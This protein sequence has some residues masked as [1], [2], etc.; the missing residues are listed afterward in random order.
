MPGAQA[1]ANAGRRLVP[2]MGPPGSVSIQALGGAI[3]KQVGAAVKSAMGGNAQ[4]KAKSQARRRKNKLSEA[5][6]NS[7]LRSIPTQVLAKPERFARGAPTS[8]SFAPRGQGLYDAFV[9]VP[10]SMVLAS[11]VG[12]VTVVEGYAHSVI[13]GPTPVDGVFEQRSLPA[14]GGNSPSNPFGIYPTAAVKGNPVIIA[15]NPGSSTSHMATVYKLVTVESANGPLVNVECEE[16]HA[17][18]LAGIGG[19]ST[20]FANPYSGGGEA[21]P[22]YSEGSSLGPGK[23]LPYGTS[24]VTGAIESIPLRGSIKFRNITEHRNIGG[25]VRVM[26]YNGGLNLLGQT[27]SNWD[28]ANGGF[29]YFMSASGNF[30]TLAGEYTYDTSSQSYT[31]NTNIYPVRSIT[32]ET[33]LEIVDMM[34]DSARSLPLSGHDLVVAHQ[35]NTYPADFVRSHTFRWDDTFQE[36]VLNPKY[37]TTL[38]LIDDFSP[39]TG[40]GS[41]SAPNNTYSITCKVQRACR[42]KP[43]TQ[44]HNKAIT[45]PADSQRHSKAAAYESLTAFARPVMQR[46]KEEFEKVGAVQAL[47]KLESIVQFGSKFA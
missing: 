40:E 3:A 9:R 30:R 8:V 44:M 42:F 27:T 36:A 5:Q 26:R 16:I 24:G 21:Q 11:Q 38:I 1:R 31:F 35:S 10:E 6:I 19:G 29:E 12:P 15:F 41:G 47:Q 17:S 33:F 37:N 20:S 22:V 28:D 13:R 7:V 39:S 2:I 45:L 34:R 25:D 43:G 23:A 46:A 32:T 4:P 18:A 14:T